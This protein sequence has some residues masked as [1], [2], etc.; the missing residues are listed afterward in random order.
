[1]KLMK[2]LIT[3]VVISL[4][5]GTVSAFDLEGGTISQNPTGSQQ[6]VIGEWE[7]NF[8]VGSN[9]VGYF[10]NVDFPKGH[11]YMKKAYD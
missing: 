6:S 10:H 4:T 5:I 11:G 1:M 8:D 9:P 3:F 7:S 2:I